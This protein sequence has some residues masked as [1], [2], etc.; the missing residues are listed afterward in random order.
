MIAQVGESYDAIA[1]P[2]ENDLD[3]I[4]STAVHREDGETSRGTAER[5]QLIH[6]CGFVISLHVR[7]KLIAVCAIECRKRG[8]HDLPG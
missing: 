2:F 8:H 7:V 4:W 5:K 6:C 1:A 3:I